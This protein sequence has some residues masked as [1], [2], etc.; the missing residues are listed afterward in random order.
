[1]SRTHRGGPARGL[2]TSDVKRRDQ[3][4][5]EVIGP[6]GAQSPR[7]PSRDCDAKHT[8]THAIAVGWRMG[9]ELYRHSDRHAA[10]RGKLPPEAASRPGSTA[11]R[12]ERRTGRPRRGIKIASQM[13]FI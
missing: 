11:R 7:R 12:G 1:V 3:F 5:L 6:P 9:R 13:A 4:R 10:C 8:S 2:P